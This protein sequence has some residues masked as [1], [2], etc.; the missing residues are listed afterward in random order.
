MNV[1]NLYIGGCSLST[2][3]RSMLSGE[4][5]H[6]LEFN[7]DSTGFPVSIKEALLNREWDFITLQQVSQDAPF[8]DTY[9]PFLAK[10]A[11]YARL[12]APK[13]KIVFHQTWAYD[14]T[15]PKLGE[16]GFDNPLQMLQGIKTASRS[17]AKD[18]AA[19]L[20]LPSGELLQMLTEHGVN[21]IHRDKHHASLGVGRYAMGLLWYSMM[22]GRDIQS[23]GYSEFDEEIP[24]EHIKIIKDCVTE[25]CQAYRK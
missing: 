11:D 19:D 4:R 20:L 5:T 16:L 9:S 6:T 21:N 13:A 22:T 12:H 14:I 15:S 1:F 8:Y 2:H 24:T 3:Y 25:L 10:L 17:A 7:G 23:N 18:I